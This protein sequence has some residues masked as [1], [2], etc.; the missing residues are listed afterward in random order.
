[1]DQLD[2]Q[3]IALLQANGRR[4]NVE[5]ARDLG[6]SEGTVRKRIDRLVSE[7]LVQLTAVVDPAR[8]GCR[9]RALIF[10]NVQLPQAQA[11]TAV[12][13]D[14]PEVMSVYQV[15]GE[16]DL[17]M[18]AAFTSDTALRDFLT[19]RVARVEGVVSSKTAHVL[20]IPK[21]GFHWAPPASET[22]QVLIVDDDPDFVEATRLV[23]EANGYTTRAAANGQAA[24][25]SLITAPPDLIIMDIMMDG[26]LDGW[27]ASWRIH[28]NAGFRHI[29]ILVV[30][31]ITSSE[32]L[33][34]LPTDDDNLIDGFFSKPV[35]PD[36]LV[37]EVARLLRRTA[38]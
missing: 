38:T 21:E 6:V 3:I 1:M 15:T 11:V 22:P 33:R 35:A 7:G 20:S 16:Y 31:S 13:R 34:M 10:L 12:L 4:T 32:Y 2:R 24:M 19:H 37:S 9:V 29:P 5:I 25:R 27:D 28:A 8:T 17:V 23:L 18:E 26:I 14:M 36:R 30:S